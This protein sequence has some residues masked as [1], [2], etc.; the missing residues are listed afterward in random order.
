MKYKYK[1]ISIPKVENYRKPVYVENQNFRTKTTKDYFDLAL[2]EA[3]DIPKENGLIV[4]SDYVHFVNCPVCNSS[5]KKQLFVKWGYKIVNCIYCDHTFVENQILPSKL[6][7][8]YKNSQV[9]KKFQ[10]RKKEKKL[11]N[12]WMLLYSKYLQLL[13]KKNPDITSLLD[14][15]AGGG[16][17]ISICHELTDFDLHAMEFSENSAEYLT[18]IVG[19]NNLYRKTISE[20]DFGDLTFDVIT[21]FGVLEHISNPL[22]ELKK[23]K[24]ILSDKGTI[25]ILVPNLYSRA[26]R[27][28]GI[29]T[30]TIN[31]RSH[32]NFFN[33]TSMNYLCDQ[34]GLVIEDYYQELPVIDLMYDFIIYDDDLVDDILKKN[35][36]YYSVYL[37]GHKH[38]T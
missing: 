32:I 37:V 25:L 22:Q 34:I 30:P 12:Y 17:F 4:A 18:S 28:L 11:N 29:S 16:D 27:I 23:C 2:Q 14:V 26:Y 35:E 10:E 36:S 31:P 6:E 21:M 13:N 38:N 5:K 3:S 7:E 15:G 9:D 20:T 33:K 1:D 24:E 8:Y 19:E